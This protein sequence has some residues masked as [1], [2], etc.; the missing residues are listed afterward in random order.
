[1]QSPF[2]GMDPYTEARHLWNLPDQ[3]YH[4]LVSRGD[5]QPRSRV[6]SFG[7][8][9]PIPT[10]PIPLA[11]AA[12][13][14]PLPLQATYATIYAARGFRQRLDY[15]SEPPGPLTEEQPTYIRSLLAEEGLLR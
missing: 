11:E 15:H 13:Y 5:E 12:E 4:I 1:M 7:L 8:A 14:V 2:P 3:P 6:W 9:D 10:T